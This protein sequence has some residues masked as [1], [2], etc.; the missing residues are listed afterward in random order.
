[1]VPPDPCYYKL[2]GFNQV[3]KLYGYGGKI[4]AWRDVYLLLQN[5]AKDVRRHDLD[6]VIGWWERQYA[7]GNLRLLLH[8]GPGMTWGMWKNAIRGIVEFVTYYQFLDMDFDI[9]QSGSMVGT[10]ILTLV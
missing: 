7:F 1:M 2:A 3:L 8:P 5:A 9:M 6:E 4:N 10:G